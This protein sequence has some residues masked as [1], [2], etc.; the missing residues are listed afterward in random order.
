MTFSPGIY[1]SKEQDSSALYFVFK[2]GLLIVDDLEGNIP[3]PS[4]DL[5]KCGLQTDLLFFGSVGNKACYAGLLDQGCVIDPGIKTKN[6][7]HLFGTI[8]DSL[9][10]AGNYAYHFIN[11]HHN[12]KFCGKCGSPMQFIPDERGKKCEKFAHMVYP[13]IS[14]CIIVAIIKDKKS[15]LLG[16][17][18]RPGVNLFSV[19][20]GFVE[21]GE[22]LEECVVREVQEEVGIEIQNI[23]YFGSQPWAFSQSLMVAFTAEYKSGQITVDGKEIPE[24]GWFDADS[25]P[26]IPFPGTIARKMI[27]WFIRETGCSE[28]KG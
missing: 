12:S 19:L 18:N 3:I 24:A 2:D 1:P 13:S 22:T 21:I 7:L 14:P 28:A 8:D 6:L 27:D 4:Q 9:F 26:T 15:I 16:K 17:I 5:T 20:A 25:L 11:W 10:A 23:Q